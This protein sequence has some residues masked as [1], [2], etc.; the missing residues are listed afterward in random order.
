[1]LKVEDRLMVL[2]F[3][4]FC[5]VPS[6]TVKSEVLA[7]SVT[8]ETKQALFMSPHT[9]L[10]SL[11]LYPSY[12]FAR[13]LGLDILRCVHRVSIDYTLRY[14]P[15]MIK[16]AETAKIASPLVTQWRSQ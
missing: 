9:M 16:E 6:T 8:I 12:Q 2:I 15:S 5:V 4:L 1:M 10:L 7:I 11:N 13:F 14:L 3:I